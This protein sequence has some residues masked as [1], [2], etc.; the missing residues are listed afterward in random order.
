MPRCCRSAPCL[1]LEGGFLRML[2]RS[3]RREFLFAGSEHWDWELQVAS[4][5]ISSSSM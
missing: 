3:G 2:L 4:V 5:P 1:A